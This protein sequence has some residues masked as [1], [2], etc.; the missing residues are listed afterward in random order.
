MDFGTFFLKHIRILPQIHCHHLQLNPR[1]V[2]A[3]GEIASL[4]VNVSPKWNSQN[5]SMVFLGFS[6][7]P[8]Q[9]V[10]YQFLG[11]NFC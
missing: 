9:Y 10:V 4:G 11:Q 8:Y 7:G 2:E 6:E 3:T 5:R 1:S